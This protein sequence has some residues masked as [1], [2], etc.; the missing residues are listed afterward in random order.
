VAR[1]LRRP[2]P[3]ESSAD[4]SVHLTHRAASHGLSR[5]PS[6][7]WEAL[8]DASSPAPLRSH[9]RHGSGPPTPGAQPTA[10][11][12]LARY[13]ARER[14]GALAAH[15][16]LAHRS[17]QPPP[18]RAGKPTPRRCRASFG[19]SPVRGCGQCG[20][21]R[22]R[23]GEELPCPAVGVERGIQSALSTLPGGRGRPSGWRTP[24]ERAKPGG[25]RR[26]H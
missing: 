4:H 24:S 8:Y 10:R 20:F 25:N 18:R 15:Q 9:G 21:A 23:K 13:A 12:R 17:T 7:A 1:T 14:P 22:R 26:F 3:P 11:R 5:S 19:R 2:S 6:R 16:L